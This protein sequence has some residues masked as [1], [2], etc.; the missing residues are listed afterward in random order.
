MQ[1]VKE[2]FE[3]V[4]TPQGDATLEGAEFQ[5]IDDTTQEA[6]GTLT[7]RCTGKFQCDQ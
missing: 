6:V 4:G 5:L 1:I 2:D 3:T 7:D